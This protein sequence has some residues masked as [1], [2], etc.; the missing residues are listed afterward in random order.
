M[1]DIS[2]L[3]FTA[4][5]PQT[6]TPPP[7]STQSPLPDPPDHPNITFIV[8]KFI[9]YEAENYALFNYINAL[10]DESE[11]LNKKRKKLEEEV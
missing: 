4:Q 1:H 6:P 7:S 3:L 8:N 9:D 2:N 11:S 10:R 5:P